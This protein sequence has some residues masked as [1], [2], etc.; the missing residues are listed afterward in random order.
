M[1][2]EL[3]LRVLGELMDWDDA[4]ASAE[5]RWLRLMAKFKYDSYEDFVAGARF[6]E[7]LVRW[8][9]QF[10]PADRRAAYA[11]VR[12]RLVFVGANEMLRLVE[13]FY[14]ADVEPVL[15]VAAAQEAGVQ[16]WEVWHDPRASKILARL[17]RQSLFMA[18]S[19]GARIDLFRRANNDW[20]SNDQVVVATQIDT[21]KWK[22]LVDSLREKLGDGEAGFR[23]IWLIDDFA[24]SGLTF[25][26]KKAT[27]GWSGKLPKFMEALASQLSA[28]AKS[29]APKWRLHVHHY[30]GT[31][32]ASIAVGNSC[33]A[34][35]QEAKEGHPEEVKVSFGLTLAEDIR[36]QNSGDDELTAIVPKYYNRD[37]ETTSTRVGGESV[38]WGFNNCGLPLV[39]H[40]N[41][42]N[43]SLALLWAECAESKDREMRALF[44]RRQRHTE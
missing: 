1:N 35:H 25:C 16:P 10:D 29:V 43:N 19:D 41:T 13:V 37:V 40:H 11:F 22:D 34:F 39:L 28:D 5:F 42:P 32:Q 15:R 27:G 4:Q 21:A 8:L 24:G 9:R 30:I 31:A 14:H 2:Q 7:S 12:S 26:R 17:R 44:R 3:A 38:M 23:F 18:L 20:L 33:H 6:I 36:L